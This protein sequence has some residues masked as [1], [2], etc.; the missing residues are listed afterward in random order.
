MAPKKLSSFSFSFHFHLFIVVVSFIFNGHFKCSFNFNMQLWLLIS[1]W[2]VV[3]AILSN[4]PNGAAVVVDAVRDSLNFVL[5]A[6]H[7]ECYFEDF[8]ADAPVRTIEAFIQSVGNVDVRLTLH[9]PLSLQDIRKV[10]EYWNIV[11]TNQLI[12]APPVDVGHIRRPYRNGENRFCERRRVR[13]IN[14]RNGVQA[15][16]SGNLRNLP[17][18]PT[19]P[20]PAEDCTGTVTAG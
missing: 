2:A 17:R 9:G 3:L 8:T 1:L 6:G 12:T 5:P 16:V 13:H 11:D 18:Q 19:I 14:L 20:L 4:G 7:R 10:T 15:R